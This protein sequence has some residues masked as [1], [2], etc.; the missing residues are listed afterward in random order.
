VTLTGV[1]AIALLNRYSSSGTL[2]TKRKL[3]TTGRRV[4]IAG[5]AAAKFCSARA[6][7]AVVMASCTRSKAASWS[8]GTSKPLTAAAKLS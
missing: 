3:S 1:F 6:N 8:C 5:P 7:G 4:K 2:L